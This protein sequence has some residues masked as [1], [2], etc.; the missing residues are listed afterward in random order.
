MHPLYV[1]SDSFFTTQRKVIMI[2]Y[3]NIFFSTFFYSTQRGKVIKALK[4]PSFAFYAVTFT[5]P[6]LNR[7][8]VVQV[9]DTTMLNKV[10]MPVT[11]IK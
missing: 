6:Q 7:I 10:I 2:V 9:S 11:K 4:S 5:Q 8:V 1:L 3:T